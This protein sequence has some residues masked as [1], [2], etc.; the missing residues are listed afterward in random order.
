MVAP[1]AYLR[2]AVHNAVRDDARAALRAHRQFEVPIDEA[3]AS[4]P[5]PVTMLEARDRLA[6][7]EQAVQ[8]L[9]PMTRQ[10]FLACR[11]DG[12][13]YAEIA[14]RTGLS[15]RGVEKQMRIAIRQLGRHLRN[16][17]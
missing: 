15:V 10:I 9:K 5:D 11:L 7:V 6:R 13:S 16:H 4:A 14:E 8:R 2:Q 12:Y 1:G 3:S 17:D